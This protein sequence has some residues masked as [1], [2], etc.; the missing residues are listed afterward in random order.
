ML[1]AEHPDAIESIN[2]IAMFLEDIGKSSAAE[3]M[4]MQR[5]APE[6]RSKVLGP[7][8]P[9]TITSINNLASCLKEQGSVEVSESM[10]RQALGLRGKVLGPKHPDTIASLNNLASCLEDLGNNA[11][12]EPLYKQALELRTRVFGVRLQQRKLCTAKCWRLGQK[13]MDRSIQTPS[14]PSTT[15]HHVWKT[16]EVF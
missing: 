9:D 3:A 12:A 6:S 10:F 13:Q 2:T 5:Q 15:S 14:R 11:A 8:H 1:G 7:E 4:Y 16:K